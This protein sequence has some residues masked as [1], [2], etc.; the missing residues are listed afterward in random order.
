M[1]REP[2][3]L[4]PAL[5][6]GARVIYAEFEDPKRFRAAVEKVREYEQKVGRKIEF[7][8]MG[9]RIHKQGEDRVT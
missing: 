2:E 8:A 6:W 9:P 3:Q 1:I 4:E 5:E 7:W